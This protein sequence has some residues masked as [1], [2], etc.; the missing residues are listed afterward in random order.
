MNKNLFP[1]LIKA[2]NDS[3]KAYYRLVFTARGD[4]WQE[5]SY[6]YNEAEAEFMRLVREAQKLVEG[7][8]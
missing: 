2:H 4:H 3:R 6:A 7:E 5:A 8:V 1:D